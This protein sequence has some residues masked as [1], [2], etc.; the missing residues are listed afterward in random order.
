MLFLG[1]LVKLNRQTGDEEGSFAM[2]YYDASSM[3]FVGGHLVSELGAFGVSSFKA[4][5][6]ERRFVVEKM[7]FFILAF[8]EV[9]RGMTN[10]P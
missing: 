7:A 9:R 8:Q 3:M 10:N 6:R 4:W 2:G 1:R 5:K